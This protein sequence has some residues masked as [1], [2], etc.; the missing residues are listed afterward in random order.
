[1][2][3]RSHYCL[4]QEGKAAIFWLDRSCAWSQPHTNKMQS[5]N[6]IY[7]HTVLFENISS[8]EAV[9][10]DNY[11]EFFLLAGSVC[12]RPIEV[13]LL[14]WIFCIFYYFLLCVLFCFVL[15]C[16]VF[17]MCFCTSSSDISVKDI[18]Q[19]T[20][21]RSLHALVLSSGYLCICAL[22]CRAVSDCALQL[23]FLFIPATCNEY[24]HVTQHKALST[25]PNQC[26]QPV[27]LTF[28]TIAQNS[29]MNT[30]SIL[31]V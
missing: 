2:C 6:H 26:M 3:F 17:V 15:F 20:Y 19:G 30:M 31:M 16:F 10:G 9:K 23:P 18:Q 5:I 4:V 14:E 22:M 8:S 21:V 24:L 1:M 25:C 11:D 29:F 27:L 12:N 28:T 7:M 13:S